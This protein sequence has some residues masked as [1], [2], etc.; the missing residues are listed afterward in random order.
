MKKFFV[1]L[2]AL[3]LFSQVHFSRAIYAIPYVKQFAVDTS[4]I[5]L[6]SLNSY[7]KLENVSDFFSNNLTLTND[8]GVTFTAGKV[9][10]FDAVN[11]ANFGASNSTKDLSSTNDHSYAGGAYSFACWLNVTTA[12]GSNVR[13]RIA[14]AGDS[15]SKNEISIDYIDTAG[16]KFIE[17]YRGKP[18]VGA[19]FYTQ[20]QIFT[21]GTWYHYVGTY[22]ATNLKLYV[23][24]AIVGTSTT[25][26]GSGSA[27]TTEGFDIGADTGESSKFSGLVD[28]CGVWQKALS[29]QE[30]TDLYNTTG[31]TM[32]LPTANGQIIDG[33]K[34]T[35]G[36]TF[37]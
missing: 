21:V 1:I 24:G 23:N 35:D 29:T 16:T 32:W 19:V 2:G 3:L 8:G 10:M 31:Q 26:T 14:M 22:D 28:E 20:P 30:I 25:A 34:A 6:G 13:Y 36:V 9:N 18:G 33:F 11:A 12:P 15:G 17:F 27:A 4:N 5:L 37:P 7:Y